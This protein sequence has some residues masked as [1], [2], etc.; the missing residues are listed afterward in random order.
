MLAVAPRGSMYDPSAV[1][2]MDKLA[3]GPDAAEVVDIRLPVAENIA[4][5]AKAKGCPPEDVTVCILDRPRHAALVEEIRATGARIKFITDGDVAGAIMAA[6]PGTGVDLLLGVGGTPEGIIAACAMKCDGRRAAGPAVPHRRRRA[7]ARD[8]RRARPR[9]GADHRRPGRAATTAS[10]SPPASPTASCCAG[11]RYRRGPLH[12]ALAGD[13]LAQRHHPR[14]QQRAPAVQ[15]ARVRVDRLRPLTVGAASV[16]ADGRVLVVG[17]ALVD[18]RLRG[19]ERTEHP[20]GSPLN[21]AVGLA[22]L[23]VPTT[24]AAQVGDD[25]R[26]AALTAHVEASGVELLRLPPHHDTATATAHAG[27]RRLGDVRVRHRLEPGAGCPTR[28]ASGWSTSGRSAP[29]CRPVRPA[30]WRW[31][32]RRRPPACRSRSTP[33]CGRA[34]LPTSTRRG[35]S[36]SELVELADVVKLSDEDAEVLWPGPAARRAC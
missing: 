35:A 24:L 21:I 29:R 14:D 12:H 30:S 8:R 16:M 5:V 19:D 25:A 33:T 23:G 27:R 3:T 1:F 34:S 20:G 13:A 22:R 36:S 4:L 17:E 26:G 32:A 15:A 28:P 9:P 2:Y 11:V 31:Y 10:S 6:R 7:A 18:V